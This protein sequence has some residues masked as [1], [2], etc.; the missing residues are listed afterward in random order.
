[1]LYGNTWDRPKCGD[2]RGGE[3]PSEGE[4]LGPPPPENR[5]FI[6]RWTFL[7]FGHL[8]SF[9]V[10]LPHLTP[11]H[12]EEQLFEDFLFEENVV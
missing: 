7:M 9:C 11:Q 3:V 6:T 2:R 1:M 5:K 8:W 12:F 10:V 4:P